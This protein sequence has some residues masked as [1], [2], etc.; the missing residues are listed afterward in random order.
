MMRCDV[1]SKFKL[2][3]WLLSLLL[4]VGGVAAVA[5]RTGLVGRNYTAKAILLLAPYQPHILSRA[6]EK[7]DPV[8]FE[9]F[10]ETQQ[11]LFK[12]RFVIVAAARDPNLKKLERFQREDA[13]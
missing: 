2:M 9:I 11:S 13:R 8:E 10:R 5:W 7:Y 4:L 6:A 3:V 12:Y 1:M